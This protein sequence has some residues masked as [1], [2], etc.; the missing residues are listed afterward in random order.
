MNTSDIAQIEDFLLKN[1]KK[2]I[3]AVL[4]MTDIVGVLIDLKPAAF[5]D[6]SSGEIKKQIA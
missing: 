5:I 4:C 6:F 3:G 2:T 1:K